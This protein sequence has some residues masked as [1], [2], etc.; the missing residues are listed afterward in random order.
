MDSFK[1]VTNPKETP[2]SANPP[3]LLTSMQMPKTQ[4][5]IDMSL[6]IA[7]EKVF[8]SLGLTP[9]EAIRLFYKQVELHQG[10]PF[11]V[12]IPERAMVPASPQPPAAYPFEE[13]AEVEDADDLKS[14]GDIDQLLDNL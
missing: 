6:K 14:Y 4:A 12:K 13:T 9:S 5:T 10:L 11:E 2:K 8:E 7:A 3:R 1:I